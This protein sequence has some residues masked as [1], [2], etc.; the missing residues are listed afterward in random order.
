M[1]SPSRSAQRR[2][3]LLGAALLLAA[4]APAASQRGT[5][6]LSTTVTDSATGQP[7]HS[8]Q[9]V[10][11][12]TRARGLTAPDGTLSLQGLPTGRYS[13]QVSLV[14]YATR[15]Q[16]AVLEAGLTTGVQL[17]L[18]VRPVRLAEVEADARTWGQRY[19]DAHGFSDRR[20]TVPGAFITRAQIEHDR[21]R[22]L[23]FMLRRFSRM[24]TSDD[25]WSSTSRPRAT[26]NL[27]GQGECVP[28][29]F[30]DGLLVTNLDIAS[31]PIDTVEG[32]EVYSGASEVPPDFNRDNRGACGAVIIWTRVH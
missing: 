9:V 2:R 14:G 10:V 15:L 7:L 31:I 1:S 17:A 23:S 28:N 8:A 18:G 32:V 21:P 3:A 20:R 13:V 25:T 16:D 6:V 22:S 12:G 24:T 27:G 4:A 29:Y 30:V 11:R 19:L 26:N 5:A